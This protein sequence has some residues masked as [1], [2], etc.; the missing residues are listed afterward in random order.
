MPSDEGE[1]RQPQA[2]RGARASLPAAPGIAPRPSEVDGRLGGSQQSLMAQAIRGPPTGRQS[3]GGHRPGA[4]AG[5]RGKPGQV[6]RREDRSRRRVQRRRL[7]GFPARGAVRE[8]D[9]GRR[10]AP[11]LLGTRAASRR[12]NCRPG[13]Q[14]GKR[15]CWP[16]AATRPFVSPVRPPPKRQTNRGNVAIPVITTPER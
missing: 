13:V 7:S 6:E 5:R 1:P 12:P 11:S 14:T 9:R 16:S 8:A 10:G 4:Q 2:E 3:A 15:Q